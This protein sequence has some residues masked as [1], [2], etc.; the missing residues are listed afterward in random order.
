MPSRDCP[1]YAG[2]GYTEDSARNAIICPWCE[3]TGVEF[4][5]ESPGDASDD[6][7]RAHRG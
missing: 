2:T 5:E 7:V 3:G 1:H 4:M 6:A